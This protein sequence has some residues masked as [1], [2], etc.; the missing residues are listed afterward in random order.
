[1]SLELKKSVLGR[2]RLLAVPLGSRKAGFSPEGHKL[3]GIY[4]TGCS[5]REGIRK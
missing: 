3:K 1:M 5:S 2:A 4:E